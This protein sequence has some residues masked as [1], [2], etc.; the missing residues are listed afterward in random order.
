MCAMPTYPT[1]LHTASVVALATGYV[2][3]LTL[4][5]A[6]ESNATGVVV[7]SV[8]WSFTVADG[9]LDFLAAGQTLVQSYNVTVTD[10]NG[11]IAAQVGTATPPNATAT[12][13]PHAPPFPVNTTGPAG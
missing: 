13:G 6:A 7:G 1:D 8:P 10:P 4:G 2:G 3:A 9:A 12:P 11:G 5:A